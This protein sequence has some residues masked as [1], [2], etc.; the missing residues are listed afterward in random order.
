MWLTEKALFSFTK[1]FAGVV[2]K[3]ES[4]KK[5][6][7]GLDQALRH[8]IQILQEMNPSEASRML[9]TIE[10]TRDMIA[11]LLL[12]TVI[13]QILLPFT[14]LFYLSLGGTIVLWVFLYLWLT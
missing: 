2:D 3:I 6:V 1:V 5:T 11:S 8:D 4:D 9:N 7:E 14:V 10:K 12:E 13:P